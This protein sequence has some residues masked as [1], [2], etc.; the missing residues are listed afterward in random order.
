[1]RSTE[2]SRYRRPNGPPS[3]PLSMVRNHSWV[4]DSG[5][6]FVS[7]SCA[8]EGS[9]IAAPPFLAWLSARVSHLADAP[10]QVGHRRR[11][12]QAGIDIR[13]ADQALV[14]LTCAVPD[15]P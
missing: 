4:K 9:V 1:M 5:Y 3:S 8:T 10:V 15:D 6:R 2:T 14:R 11:L 13:V 12:E 7:W